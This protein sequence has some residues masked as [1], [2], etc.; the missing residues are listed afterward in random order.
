MS[1]HAP[2][3]WRANGKAILSGAMLHCD[4]A[5]QSDTAVEHR[6]KCA[7]LIG[8]RPELVATFERASDAQLVVDMRESLIELLE[9][10]RRHVYTDH[11]G[12]CPVIRWRGEYTVADGVAITD[13][14]ALLAKIEPTP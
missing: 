6:E 14:R 1:E 9:V 2:S 12:E 7:L 3:P 8:D 5:S 4:C 10:T 13:A 11:T